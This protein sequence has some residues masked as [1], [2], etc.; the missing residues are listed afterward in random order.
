[1]KIFNESKNKYVQA[2]ILLMNRIYNGECI[3]VKC[4]DK[5]FLKKQRTMEAVS[6]W[7]TLPG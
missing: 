5:E 2:T 1:M 6:V 3:P 7:S 4:F